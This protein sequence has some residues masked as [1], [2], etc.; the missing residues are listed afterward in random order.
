MDADV[1]IIGLGPAGLQAA[2][3]AARK[4]VKV[5]ALGKS[6]SSA[7]NK[8]EVVNFFGILSMAGPELLRIGREQAK[9]FGA[10]IVEEDVMKVVKDGDEFKI[11]TLRSG[12]RR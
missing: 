8:A 5:V 7:L 9:N 2:I 12:P 3:H 1:A 4:K 10:T 6:E 11:I